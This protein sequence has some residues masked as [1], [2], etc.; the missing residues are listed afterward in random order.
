MPPATTNGCGT[1]LR[2]SKFPYENAIEDVTHR[3]EVREREFAVLDVPAI[4]RPPAPHGR[5]APAMRR[6]ARFE[7][8]ERGFYSIAGAAVDADGTLYFVDRHQQ[9]IFS[10]S[11]ARG[12]TSSAMRRSIR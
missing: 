12:L 9:R 2:A 7:T 10:W 5:A 1:F 8:L 6:G 11:P 4:Q 3:L